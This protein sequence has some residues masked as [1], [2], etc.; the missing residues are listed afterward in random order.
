M[1]IANP[2]YLLHDRRA[3]QS[4]RAAVDDGE[5]EPFNELFEA[6]EQPHDERDGFVAYSLPPAPG[7]RVLQSIC[8]TLYHALTL[9]LPTLIASII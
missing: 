7:E 9:R 4:I 6:L 1:C 2:A 8:G 5:C 3:E